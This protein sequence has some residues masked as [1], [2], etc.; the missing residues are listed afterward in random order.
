MPVAHRAL[1]LPLL[2]LPVLRAPAQDAGQP[3]VFLMVYGGL[4]SGQTLWRVGQPL[5]VWQ[6]VPGGYQCESAPSGIVNDTLTL[7]RRV[8]T[9]FTAGVGLAKY[10]TPA[11]GG[12][13]DFW[14]AEE[15]F[16]DRCGATAFQTDSSQKNQQ[17]CTSFAM[18]HASLSLV[19]LAGSALFR[20]FPNG[21]LSPYVRLGVG[22]V[23]PTGETL[24][25][26]GAFTANA[27]QLDR[28]MIQDSSGQGPRPYGVLA[29]GLQSGAGVTSR[30]QLE[31]TDAIVPLT[32]ITGPADIAGRAPQATLLTHHFSAT[33]GIVL[34]FSGRR[35]RRY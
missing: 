9:G 4:A 22:I 11:F 20:P 16:E 1:L 17:T 3:A 25:A 29:V 27:T 18:D 14:Y 24:A 21:G 12:R 32:R 31:L 13:L 6:T 28:Q 2:L 30:V 26:S 8:G 35:G 5:C 19:G 7:S 23:L 10:F 15:S 33:V 34:V